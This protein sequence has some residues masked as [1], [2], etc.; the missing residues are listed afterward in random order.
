[1]KEVDEETVTKEIFFNSQGS[2]LIHS[3]NLMLSIQMKLT[4]FSLLNQAL[5]K[6]KKSDN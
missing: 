2:L 4:L 3:Y 1:M 5:K 6:T